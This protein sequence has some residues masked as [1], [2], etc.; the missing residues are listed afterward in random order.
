LAELLTQLIQILLQLVGALLQF[1]L[2]RLHLCALAFRR[3]R[4]VGHLAIQVVLTPGEV[5]RLLSIWIGLAAA[6][7]SAALGR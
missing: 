1:L 3:L 5:E 2:L 4:E 6:R 7:L